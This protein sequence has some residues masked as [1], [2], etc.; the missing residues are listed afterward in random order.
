[1]I[2]HLPSI[3]CKTKMFFKKFLTIF[4]FLNFNL[5]QVYSS[6]LFPEFTV[7]QITFGLAVPVEVPNRKL[8]I[9]TCL[10]TNMQL[11]FRIS[12]FLNPTR[13]PGLTSKKKRDIPNLMIDKYSV[14]KTND[15][16]AGEV[17]KQVQEFLDM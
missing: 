12:D 16:S 6:L 7:L 13:F 8:F 15:L 14:N 1:M 2:L 17:Y 9:N 11:P 5:S 10:Q 4:L 3:V